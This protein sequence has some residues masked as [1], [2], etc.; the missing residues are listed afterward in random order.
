MS[1]FAPAPK[2]IANSTDS[3]YAR[4]VGR[5]GALAVAL[6]VSSAFVSWPA[7]LAD[8]AGSTGS[9]E[10]SSASAG[11]ASS[12]SGARGPQRGPRSGSG[13]SDGPGSAGAVES[14]RRS[15]GG[16]TAAGTG[17][18]QNTG[19]SSVPGAAEVSR[20]NTG[21]HRADTV[22]PPTADVRTPELGTPSQ[23]SSGPSAPAE[24]PAGGSEFVDA[25]DGSSLTS[26]SAPAAV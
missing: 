6:G 9:S 26:L 5:V 7:A 25:R 17:L 13:V 8:T 3:G 23:V 18:A 15:R 16:S 12:P 14:G 19:D 24:V 11:S 22:L 21:R 20:P 10:D 2:P 1:S 4:Y